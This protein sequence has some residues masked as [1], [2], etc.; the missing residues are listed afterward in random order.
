MAGAREAAQE[1]SAANRPDL[2]EQQDSQLGVLDE[3]ASQVKV[4]SREEIRNIVEQEVSRLKDNGDKPN[5]G[6]VL[7]RLFSEQGSL[8][9]KAQTSVAAQ[10]IKEA[11]SAS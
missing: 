3:Y 5:I 6:V 1:F 4:L 8:N 9:N 11:L 7:A 10:V 2:K